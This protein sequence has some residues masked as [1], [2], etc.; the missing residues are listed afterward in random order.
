MPL[1]FGIFDLKRSIMLSDYE[2]LLM[3]AE[4][5]YLLLFKPHDFA[6]CCNG[7]GSQVG[8]FFRRMLYRITPNTIW[9]LNIT[10]ASNIHD[11]EYTYPDTFSTKEEALK[12]KEKSDDRFYW[13]LLELIHRKGGIFKKLRE[14]RAFAYYKLL[15]IAG[16]FSFLEGKTIIG[17]K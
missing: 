8:G 10:L 16:E 1:F 5:K 14:R 15:L 2:G 4:T 3:C 11:V 9:L 6:A 7:V 17:E 13:N 12:H